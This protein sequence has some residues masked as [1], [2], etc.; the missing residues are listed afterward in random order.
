MSDKAAMVKTAVVENSVPIFVVLRMNV[1]WH[2]LAL[3]QA[4]HAEKMYTKSA[5]FDASV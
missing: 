2:Q 1:D 3:P 5:S 4:Y